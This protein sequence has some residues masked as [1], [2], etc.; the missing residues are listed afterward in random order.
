MPRI[1][2]KRVIFPAVCV[3]WLIWTMCI[4]KIDVCSVLDSFDSYH[5]RSCLKR[6]GHFP[7]QHSNYQ[8]WK[9][10]NRAWSLNDDLIW[11]TLVLLETKWTCSK[12]LT[13]FFH[14]TQHYQH[15]WHQV[16]SNA[17]LVDYDNTAKPSRTRRKP[18]LDL[19][20]PL[21]KRLY[22]V[23]CELWTPVITERTGQFIVCWLVHVICIKYLNRVADIFESDWIASNWMNYLFSVSYILLC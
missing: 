18:D 10:I 13:I 22:S 17:L 7:V 16:Y 23:K 20:I 12:Q 6:P 15:L 5:L 2:S 1:E 8:Q 3:C 21:F 9:P 11:K 19:I 14:I 4:V